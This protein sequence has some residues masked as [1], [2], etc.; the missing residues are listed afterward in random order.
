MVLFQV[1]SQEAVRAGVPGVAC[2]ALAVLHEAVVQGQV[3]SLSEAEVLR[4][5]I[6]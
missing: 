1:V 4:A 3:E 6:R 5:H 2:A